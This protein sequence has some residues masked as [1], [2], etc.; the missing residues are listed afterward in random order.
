M[1]QI[2][3]V[4]KWFPLMGLC[5]GVAVAAWLGVR[6]HQQN[7][8]DVEEAFQLVAQRTTVQ[9]ERRMNIYEYGLRGTRGALITGGEENIGRAGFLRYSGSRDYAVEFPGARGFGFIRRVPAQDEAA[10]VQA[11]RADGW[12]GFNVRHLAPHTRERF[13]IQ[14]IEPAQNNMQAIGLDIASEDNR[15]TAAERAMRTGKAV[16]TDPI[17]LVQANGKQNQGFLILLPA[18]RNGAPLTTEAEREAAG[19]GWAYTP[20]T[21]EE[22]LKD[23]DYYEGR[24]SVSLSAVDADGEPF[25]FY[26]NTEAATAAT[27]DLPRT[28]THIEIF[29]KEWQI[30]VQAQPELIEQMNLTSPWLVFGIVLLLSLVVTVATYALQLAGLRAER[31]ES[32]NRLHQADRRYR[33]LIDG[34]RDYAIVQLDTS[35]NVMGWNIGAKEITGYSESEIAGRHL[36]VFYPPDTVSRSQLAEKLASARDVGHAHEEG[37]RLRKDGSRFWASVTLTPMYDEE[38]RLSGY[39]KITRDL[40]ERRAQELERNR[41]FGL[42]NAILSSAGIAIIAT[43]M[44]GI[45]T[46]FNP[47]AER[48]LGYQSDEV[49]G[50]LTPAAFHDRDEITRR[51]QALSEE[52]GSPVKPG[53]ATLGVKALQGKVDTNEWTYYTKDGQRKPVLLSVTGIFDEHGNPLGSLGVATDLSD[54][55]RYQAELEAARE[56]AEKANMAKSSFLANMSHEIRTP[57]NAILGMTQLVLQGELAPQQRTMLTKAFSA[58]KALLNILNDVLDYSKVEAGHMHLEAR[59]L[60]L[61]TLLANSASLFAHQAEQKGLSFVLDIPPDLPASVRGDPLRL[62]QVLSNLLSNALK[63]TTEGAIT[64][65]ARTVQQDS[66]MC[67]VR[68][69]VADSGIGMSAAQMAQLFNPFTQADVS[70]TRKYGGTGL[71]LSICKRLVELM[72]GV[73]EVHSTPGEGSEFFFEIGMALPTAPQTTFRAARPLA[74]QRALVVDDQI[75]SAHVLQAMLRAWGVDA[76]CCDSGEAALHHIKTASADGQHFDLLLTDWRMPGM[77]G[78]ELITQIGRLASF[79]GLTRIPAMVMVSAYAR[80]ELAARVQDHPVA[81]LL[82]KPV[83]PSAL[84]NALAEAT[85]GRPADAADVGKNAARAPVL[86]S[87]I[88]A[89]A[90]LRGMRVLLAEDNEVNQQVATAFLQ[91]AGLEVSIACNGQ[92]AVELAGS[93]HFAAI[94]MDMHMPEMDG[95]EATRRIRTLAP[96]AT[97]P[98]IAMTA[99]VMPEDRRACFDAGMDGFVGKP[100]DPE[101]LIRA[102]CQWTGAR[103]AAPSPTGANI[104]ANPRVAAEARDALGPLAPLEQLEGVDV[105]GALAR[106]GGDRRLYQRL[107]R[108]FAHRA[109]RLPDELTGLGPHELPEWIHRLKGE[110][111]NLGFHGIAASCQ[112]LENDLKTSPDT[113]PEGAVSALGNFLRAFS[114]QLLQTLESA[115]TPDVPADPAQR[116]LGPQDREELDALLEQLPTLLKEQRMQALK[117]SERLQELLQGTPWQALYVPVHDK[118]QQ[119]QFAAALTALEEVS[120]KLGASA[121]VSGS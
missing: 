59:E 47:S 9:L 83:L 23:F 105:H 114:P 22:V 50:K 29:G 20:L 121:P 69:S 70:V 18:Y 42:Q 41:L 1:K 16:I 97:V 7:Q 79:Q 51:A 110:S 31:M 27:A 96:C 85:H 35:G 45:I 67:R 49:I 108:D 115:L 10:F 38:G 24:I 102:L 75:A 37:W 104:A 48:L 86:H 87:Y 68:F 89:A 82:T 25:L 3:G 36:S 120:G 13:V 17:T 43:R 91:S 98:I 12:P 39:S 90:P 92:Q 60:S 6:T 52:L 55:K 116:S 33:Q 112:S 118:I 56:T 32:A 107:L 26:S 80:D 61:E 100:I 44:D 46:L 53:L 103:A 21:I 71:G 40:S 119:L 63:F 93:G 101:E 94:L 64:L 19:Y 11:A 111:G 28:R 78:L 72:G 65:G 106:M 62:T 109:A 113:L 4:L 99:A 117:D 77:D 76:L 8:S 34:V 66:Q 5:V 30:N 2:S 88:A 84:H 15:R 95:L 57:M 14:Y 81:A 73:I 58:S 54:Q 74:F